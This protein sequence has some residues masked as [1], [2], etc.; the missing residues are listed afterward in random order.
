MKQE[1]DAAIRRQEREQRIASDEEI[2]N[3]FI[4]Q[5]DSLRVRRILRYSIGLL[6]H[7]SADKRTAK[8]VAKREK[9][10]ADARRA[11]NAALRERASNQ[12]QEWTAS[13]DRAVLSAKV[14]DK[15]IAQKLGRTLLAVRTRRRVLEKRGPRLS[16]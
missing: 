8:A 1:L 14:P 16:A 11:I 6:R 13:Q 4:A 10:R 12:G 2:I 15:D 3:G 5:T 9:K 7:R